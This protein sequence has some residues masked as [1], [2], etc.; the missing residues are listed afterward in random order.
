MK[1]CLIFRQ[2]QVQIC[3]LLVENPCSESSTGDTAEENS[4]TDDFYS[5]VQKKLPPRIM[6]GTEK[7]QKAVNGDLYATVQKRKSSNIK[8]GRE[9]EVFRKVSNEGR[10]NIKINHSEESEEPIYATIDD[11]RGNLKE[12]SYSDEEDELLAQIEECEDLA[13]EALDLAAVAVTGDNHG[14]DHDGDKDNDDVGG[15]DD[16]EVGGDVDD[17]EEEEETWYLVHDILHCVHCAGMVH[18][19]TEVDEATK[20]VVEAA[21]AVAGGNKIPDLTGLEC[22]SFLHCFNIIIYS[23]QAETVGYILDPN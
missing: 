1:I 11:R 2:V 3:K 15:D 14:E 7:Y 4:V 16:E 20:A 13:M 22:H 23:I 9:V 10:L 21:K 5:T 6:E 19:R 12:E 8:H 18:G 17:E